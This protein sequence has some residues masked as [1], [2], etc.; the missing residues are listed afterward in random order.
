[1][2]LNIIFL[3]PTIKS[4]IAK[5]FGK[6]KSYKINNLSICHQNSYFDVKKSIHQR[7][8]PT[9]FAIFVGDISF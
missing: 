8:A 4:L 6:Y 1:M 7:L 3:K 9:I 2:Q 5:Y